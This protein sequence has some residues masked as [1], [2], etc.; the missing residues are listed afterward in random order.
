MRHNTDD[1]NQWI[2]D[3][4][5]EYELISKTGSTFFFDEK[6]YAQLITYY[7][8]EEQLD[9]A[10][11]VADHALNHHGFSVDF[12]IK[13]AQLLIDLRREY[14]ALDVLDQAAVFAPNELEI[15][16]LRAEALTYI[17]RSEEALDLLEN[18]KV[19]AEGEDLSDI[20]LV[21]AIVYEYEEEYERMFYALKAALQEFPGN[22]EAL[23]RLWLAVDLTRKY[24]ES[25]P[26]LEEV[27]N[28]DPYAFLAW[29][30]LGHAYAYLGHYEEAIDSYEYAFVINEDFE[31][32][33]RDCAELCFELKQ[34]NKALKYYTEILENFEPDSEVLLCIGQCYQNLQNYLSA[35]DFYHRALHFDPLNDEV[36]FHIGECY[37]AEG[38]WRS[39][40]KC[41]QK[42]ISIEDRQEDYFAA[43][44]AAFMHLK[45]FDKAQEAFRQATT[46]APESDR[47]WLQYATFLLEIDHAQEALYVLEEAE[48]SAAGASLLYGRVACLFSLGKRREAMALLGEALEEEY[49]AHLTLFEMN[50]TL[51]LDPEVLG[52]IAAYKPLDS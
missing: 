34:F 15:T 39:A 3:L 7:E 52:L 2:Q 25:I 8:K 49:E 48:E 46:L 37:A 20:L 6:A 41:Y 33:Y 26:M 28:N 17:D 51:G 42:A 11:E 19:S 35:R 4:V 1:N 31:F 38:K 43:Q 10:L 40:L 23:E 12:Y 5:A 36:H 22:L 16:L 30:N 47:F 27:I 44:A 14:L 29:Y 32:A 9:R 21:E 24:E 18:S 13:K 50:P 45:E